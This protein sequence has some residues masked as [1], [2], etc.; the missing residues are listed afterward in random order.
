MTMKNQIIKPILIAT[1]LVL[2]IAGCKKEDQFPSKTVQVTYP[3]IELKGDSIVSITVGTTYTDAGAT[4]IDDI[5]GASSDL[6]ASDNPVDVNTPGLYMV[7]YEA[8]NANG[9]TTV[10]QRPVLVTNI[11]ASW[12][13]TGVYQRTSNGVDVNVT[14]VANGLYVIDNVGGVVSSSPQFIFPVYMGQLDDSTITIPA[15]YIAD[16]T[17]LDADEETLTVQPG[18]TSYSYV[19]LNPSFGESVRTFVKQ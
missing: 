13:L 11:D 10:K 4:L 14:E 3:G 7:T 18:D 16:K 15:Q 19:V 9:F 8:S 6:E 1:A 5:T 17:V 12:D 2:M